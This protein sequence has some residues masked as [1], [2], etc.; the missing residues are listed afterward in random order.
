ML[1]RHVRPGVDAYHTEGPRLLPTMSSPPRPRPFAMSQVRQA[2]VV[3]DNQLN[4][5]LIVVFFKRLG[6]DPRLADSGE[7]ALAMLASERFDRC[8][9][10]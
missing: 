5:R 1:C 6:W 2:L 9:A 4:S 8:P 3:D 7:A 10:R